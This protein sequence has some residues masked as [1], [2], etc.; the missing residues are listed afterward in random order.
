MTPMPTD[1]RTHPIPI[2]ELAPAPAM[3]DIHTFS[4]EDRRV[5]F[6]AV[7]EALELCGCWLLNRRPTSL[8]QVEF[9]FEL[10]LRSVLDLYA[11]LIAAGLEL[12]R[13]SH[14]DLTVLCSLRKHQDHPN[15]LAGVVTVHLEV[16][17]LEESTP[18]PG[19]SSGA[20]YA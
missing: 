12:T 2:P 10:Q 5:I 1:C 4:Y 20:A 3:L 17:F 9:Q 14:Q 7:S 19:L 18:I 6:P 13:A 11:A 8:T 16:N 15:S